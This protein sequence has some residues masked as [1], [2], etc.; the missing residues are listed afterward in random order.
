MMETAQ[1]DSC[2][3]TL[4]NWWLIRKP[5]ATAFNKCLAGFPS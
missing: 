2:D 1:W 3:K 5:G 4:N